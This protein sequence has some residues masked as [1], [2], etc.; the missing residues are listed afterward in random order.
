[1]RT[2]PERHAAL[3]V[4]G[5]GGGLAGVA[6]LFS[7]GSSSSR[8]LWLGVA[9]PRRSATGATGRALRWGAGALQPLVERAGPLVGVLQPGPRVRGVRGDG[10]RGGR[11]RPAGGAVVGVRAGR[12]RRAR[13]RLGAAPEGRP[14]DRRLRSRG[15]AQL[16]GRLLERPRVALRSRR[17]LGVVARGAAGPSALASR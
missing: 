10:A 4:L 7:A 6:A 13:A 11:L 9:A 16:A 1:M 8:L 3:L 17:P 12:C 15:A 2:A 5:A 14:G